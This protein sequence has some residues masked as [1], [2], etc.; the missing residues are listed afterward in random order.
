MTNAYIDNTE[1]NFVPS[2]NMTRIE[3]ILEDLE[4]IYASKDG[5]LMSLVYSSM[6]RYLSAW[7][8]MNSIQDSDHDDPTVNFRRNEL[9]SDTIL[10]LEGQFQE[11]ADIITWANYQLPKET[12]IKA[13]DMMDFFVRSEPRTRE[14]DEA[15]V[16]LYSKAM[17]VPKKAA[18][19]Y[20]KLNAKEL[21][22]RSVIQQKALKANESSIELMMFGVLTAMPTEF[23]ISNRLASNICNKIADKC[24][25]YIE[26]RMIRAASTRRPRR[27]TEIAGEVALLTDVMNT[28][29]EYCQR[30][31]EELERQRTTISS[32]NTTEIH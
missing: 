9:N 17:S 7:T 32:P 18:M 16:E 29:D 28:T 31:E 22:E 20:M 15:L 30:Y 11:N 2:Y 1:D 3:R 25:Q 24:D 27:L 8:Q 6:A 13:N 10:R 14:T 12:K 19:R 23:E 26:R 5:I 21:H 4:P